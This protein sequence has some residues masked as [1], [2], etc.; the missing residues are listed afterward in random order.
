MSLAE[1]L[2]GV[3][4]MGYQ[5]RKAQRDGQESRGFDYAQRRRRIHQIDMVTGFADMADD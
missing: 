5:S 1:S 3:S 4:E 2:Q